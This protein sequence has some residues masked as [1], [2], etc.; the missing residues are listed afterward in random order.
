MDL[1]R[2]S[3]TEARVAGLEQHIKHISWTLCELKKDIRWLEDRI[4]ATKRTLND[5]IDSLRR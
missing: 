2:V 1:T 5:R 3:A 4:D